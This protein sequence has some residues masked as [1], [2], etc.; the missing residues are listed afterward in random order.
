MLRCSGLWQHSGAMTTGATSCWHERS[1]KAAGV[2]QTTTAVPG[3]LSSLRIKAAE[4]PI[5]TVRRAAAAAA[6]TGLDVSP[7]VCEQPCQRCV[8]SRRS[9][10]SE[11]R[12]CTVLCCV[13]LRWPSLSL[14]Q[15][16][17][18][19]RV[20]LLVCLVV[21]FERFAALWVRVVSRRL[22][23]DVHTRD[24]KY[25]EPLHPQPL[26]RTRC[27]GPRYTFDL[28]LEASPARHKCTLNALLGSTDRSQH[29]PH[30]FR[31]FACPAH[32]AFGL[33]GST[34]KRTRG[35]PHPPGLVDRCWCCTRKH[36][37][38]SAATIQI[39]NWKNRPPFESTRRTDNK[40]TTRSTRPRHKEVG[41]EV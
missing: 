9:I 2:H 26:I 12:R 41:S 33:G 37:R 39:N 29:R 17:H 10:P 4:R 36:A 27:R 30:P 18:A 1:V 21:H 28:V 11:H 7:K 40:S 8:T 22:V 3:P 13:G 6:A 38:S 5:A 32:R 20:G 31:G 24:L 23:C 15:G 14:P 16:G 19:S 35:R 34:R 25:G